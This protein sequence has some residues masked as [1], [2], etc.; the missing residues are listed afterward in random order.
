[1]KLSTTA[2]FLDLYN[3]RALVIFCINKQTEI[4]E[5]LTCMRLRFVME[6]IVDEF[7]YLLFPR[8]CSPPL[9]QSMIDPPGKL[10]RR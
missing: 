2:S 5:F 1:M 4:K 7:Y 6:R 8:F 10:I 9:L 3:S